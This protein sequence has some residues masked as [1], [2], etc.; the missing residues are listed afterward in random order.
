MESRNGSDERRAGGVYGARCDGGGGNRT[1][2]G[3]GGCGAGVCASDP[4]AG[5]ELGVAG[6]SAGD[7]ERAG[8]EGREMGEGERKGG[9]HVWPLY[10]LAVKASMG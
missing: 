9:G 3:S 8:S 4:S 6:G 1:S 2:T 5:D 7:G 10:M